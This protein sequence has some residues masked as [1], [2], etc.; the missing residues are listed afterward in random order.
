[1]RSAKFFSYANNFIGEIRRDDLPICRFLVVI[2]ISFQITNVPLRRHGRPLHVVE[3]PILGRRHLLDQIRWI[4][5][6]TLT[7]NSA[8]NTTTSSTRY[9]VVLR[10]LAVLAQ[11]LRQDTSPGIY[12][13]VA[14]LRKET[15]ILYISK[16]IS[17]D[18]QPARTKC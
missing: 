7:S 16:S 9:R 4:G 10:I 18:N 1:M 6:P 17:N 13:P 12:K 8:L 15:S 5:P 2:V 14:N 11:D 3:I